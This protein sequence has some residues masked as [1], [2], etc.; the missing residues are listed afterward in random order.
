MKKVIVLATAA[1]LFVGVANARKTP[2]EMAKN[3]AKKKLKQPQLKL[4]LSQ[5]LNELV[6]TI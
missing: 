6:D 1:F 5:K 4:L 2:K 3:A